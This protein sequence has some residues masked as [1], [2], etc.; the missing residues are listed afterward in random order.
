MKQTLTR[1]AFWS[2]TRLAKRQSGS[3]GCGG[4][5]PVKSCPLTVGKSLAEMAEE[6]GR[7]VMTLADLLPVLE[8]MMPTSEDAEAFGRHLEELRGRKIFD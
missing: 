3:M 6:Q 2:G 4:W 7:D 8:A 5:R 1:G